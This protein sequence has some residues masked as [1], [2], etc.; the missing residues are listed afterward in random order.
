MAF[1]KMQVEPVF[2]DVELFL[3]E[4]FAPEELEKAIKG[5]TREQIA[6]ATGQNKSSISGSGK[7][8]KIFVDGHESSIDSITANT[9]EIHVTFPL[10][11]DVLQWIQDHLE[12]NSPVGSP[13]KD[14]HPGLYKRSHT[15]Y[16]DGVETFIGPDIAEAEEYAFINEVIY[17]RKIEHGQS[18]QAPDGVYQGVALLAARQFSKVAKIFFSYRESLTFGRQPAVIVKPRGSNR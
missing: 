5:F 9:R 8:Y 10:V 6:K 12:L 17:A 4:G 7:N 15:I 1:V 16:A 18:K 2:R 13:P 11:E 3:K 14:K